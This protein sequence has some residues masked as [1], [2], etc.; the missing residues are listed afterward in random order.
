MPVC[1]KPAY[2]WFLV[3]VKLHFINCKTKSKI[4]QLVK[5]QTR[6]PVLTTKAGLLWTTYSFRMTSMEE[7]R[8]NEAQ[9]DPTANC[10]ERLQLTRGI[11]YKAGFWLV[12]ATSG[13][14]L[15]RPT[16]LEQSFLKPSDEVSQV[17]QLLLS[18]SI[19]CDDWWVHVVVPTSSVWGVPS[20][21]VSSLW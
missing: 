7:A 13:L 14:T 11:Y 20:P 18:S 2:N 8:A 17:S 1:Y 5:I 12:Q 6:I 4:S 16:P 19:L 3:F 10:W 9:R 15:G 21:C